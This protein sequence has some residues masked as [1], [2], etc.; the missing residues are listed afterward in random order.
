MKIAAEMQELEYVSKKN[1][2]WVKKDLALNRKIMRQSQSTWS[3]KSYAY[4]HTDK[5]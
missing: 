5:K 2:K 4:M 1:V 3:I